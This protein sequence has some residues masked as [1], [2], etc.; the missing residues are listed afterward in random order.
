MDSQAPNR[1]DLNKESTADGDSAEASAAPA[2]NTIRPDTT[3]A[4][5]VASSPPLSYQE[6][7]EQDPENSPPPSAIEPA[8]DAEG[9]SDEYTEDSI[10]SDSNYDSGTDSGHS[11]DDEEG[12]G[13]PHEEITAGALDTH[14]SS[15]TTSPNSSDVLNPTRAAAALAPAR[16]FVSHTP[17]GSSTGRL[18]RNQR[19]KGRLWDD[20]NAEPPSVA[21]KGGLTPAEFASA[22]LGPERLT[23]LAND[24]GASAPSAVDKGGFGGAQRAAEA[25]YAAAA[26]SREQ[27]IQLTQQLHYQQQRLHQMQAQMQQQQSAQLHEQAPLAANQVVDVVSVQRDTGDFGPRLQQDAAAD[28]KAQLGPRAP[29]IV[30]I[31]QFVKSVSR[32]LRIGFPSAGC[33]EA[34][35][36]VALVAVLGVRTAL[37]VWF[38]NFNA[39]SVHAVVTYD[40]AMLLRRLLPEYLGMMVP[41][42]AVNQAIKWVIGSLTIALRVRLGRYA[43]E[44]YVDGITNITWNQLHRQQRQQQQQGSSSSGATMTPAYE[45][46][47]WLL[48]VQIHRFADMLPRLIADVVKPTMD[49]F[50]F[51]RLLSKFIGRKGSLA[52]VAYVVLANVV[53]RLSSPPM[54]KNASR[55]AQLEEKYRGVYARIST[56]I[57]RAA[58]ASTPLMFKQEQQQQ[59]GEKSA[60]VVGGEPSDNSIQQRSAAP[61]TTFVPRVQAAFRRRAQELLDGSLDGVAGSV[62]ST[63]IRR[64]F[65]GIGETIVAKYGATLTAYYLLSRP[66]CAAAS[67]GQRLAQ[68]HDPAAVM[69]SYSRNSA[70]L[71]NLSQATTRLLLMLNDLPKFVWSTVKVDRLLTSLDVHAQ[72]RSTADE[73]EA[74]AEAEAEG[75]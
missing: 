62:V 67:A 12:I 35:L 55:L 51:S 63:N 7:Q 65:G 54:G 8:A 13:Q 69:M 32:L 70:Y 57:Q 11:V 52:M 41:M 71:I 31:A 39:R 21:S 30:T 4:A 47:D 9:C 26:A 46:P 36:T 22:G 61:T 42:A 17:W 24:G 72:Y 73:A 18:T 50:V 1:V 45:R 14:F 27:I 43:H 10:F 20:P 23:G 56:I 16:H 3:Y 48:T 29:R 2:T 15:G 40:R 53:I 64:F 33:T 58:A 75:S 6:T 5:A 68:H 34:R 60:E 28:G 38:S 44:R 74:E 49:W 59:R 37:D 25:E 19:H 66:L